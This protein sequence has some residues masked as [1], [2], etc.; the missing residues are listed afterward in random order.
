MKQI[1]DT[2][3]HRS[4]KKTVDKRNDGAVGNTLEILLGIKENNLPIANSH[5]WELKGQRKHTSSLITLKHIEP[6]PTGAKIVSTVLLPKY[7]WK[8]KEAGRKY[9]EEE[10][11]FRSTTSATSYTKRGFKVIVDRI[12]RK[13]IFDFNSSMVE[14]ADADVSLWYESV[15]E[16][17]GTGKINPEPYWG[18]DDLKYAIG[19]KLMNCFYVI[20]DAKIEDGHE[21]FKYEKLL[22]LSSFS[23][24]KFVDC[25]EQGHLY[26][27][28]DARTGHNH[29]TKFRLT[30][31]KLPELYDSATYVS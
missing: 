24:D 16:R 3:W 22:I 2:G 7:G 23:F 27:D 20:A 8:H 30:Q 29:G 31:D 6:S 25:V 15:K 10:M 1:I 5:E 21:Y 14:I 11:S 9:S 17:I 4:V 28:F 13:L 19:S 12:Q 18:F 26:I